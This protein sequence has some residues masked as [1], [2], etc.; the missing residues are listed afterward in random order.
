MGMNIC[1]LC[2]L[3]HVCLNGTIVMIAVSKNNARYTSSAETVTAA[4]VKKHQPNT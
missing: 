4:L 1:V 3:S 2:I